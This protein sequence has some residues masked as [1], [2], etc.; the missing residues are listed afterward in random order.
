MTKRRSAV[1][2]KRGPGIHQPQTNQNTR[3]AGQVKP[4]ISKSKH[5]K[6]MQQ[7]ENITLEMAA[8]RRGCIWF[9]IITAI[10]SVAMCSATVAHGQNA[11]NVEFR[12]LFQIRAALPDTILLIHTGYN[13]RVNQSGV[14]CVP[15]NPGMT[16]GPPIPVQNW[17]QGDGGEWIGVTKSGATV[18]LFNCCGAEMFLEIETAG[19]VVDFYN[20]VPAVLHWKERNKM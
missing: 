11:P 8:I 20:M 14:E 18:T 17:L 4:I 12:S 15:L 16:P 10:I 19:Q 7:N 1:I 9:A 3:P 6:E 13:I 2:G 5:G